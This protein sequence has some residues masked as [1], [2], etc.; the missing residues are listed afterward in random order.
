MSDNPYAPPESVLE[1]PRALSALGAP[2]G[3]R[4]DVGASFRWLFAD[5]DW[6]KRVGVV[7]LVAWFPLFGQV[8][9][10]GWLARAFEDVREGTSAG[11]APVD[12]GDAFVRGWR[13]LVAVG[14]TYVVLYLG[15]A[16]VVAVLV[17]LLGP[18]APSEPLSSTG[19]ENPVEALVL[20]PLMVVYLGLL[21]AL[22]FVL[23]EV[24]R[25]AMRGELV[26]LVGAISSVGAITRSPGAYLLTVMVLWVIQFAGSMGMYLFCV[27][28]FF[29]FPAAMALCTHLLAQ[30]DAVVEHNAAPS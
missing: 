6:W 27:G 21:G 17:L 5:P 18:A 10:L 2:S 14:S 7:G 9:L 1:L 11:V 13:P 29:T 22:L 28:W 4:V 19:G 25:R 23:P 20:L 30:W 3:E 8:V 24:F 12:L 16:M 26:P 15:L